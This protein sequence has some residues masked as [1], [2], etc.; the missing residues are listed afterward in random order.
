MCN[1][2]VESRLKIE[3]GCKLL[4]AIPFASQSRPL[5]YGWQ[6]IWA[7]FVEFDSPLYVTAFSA[8]I[9]HVGSRS[10]SKLSQLSRRTNTEAVHCPLHLLWTV[11]PA[12]PPRLWPRESAG[13]DHP[14]HSQEKEAKKERRTLSLG[15]GDSSWNPN[16]DNQDG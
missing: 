16:R 13:S 6:V 10:L 15:P 5:F 4:N 11:K 3:G 1:H 7:D 2:Y 9:A 14:H 12:C 8:L